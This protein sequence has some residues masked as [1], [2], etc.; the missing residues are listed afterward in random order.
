MTRKSTE[1]LLH[2]GYPRAKRSYI[3]VSGRWI[4]VAYSMANLLGSRAE[5]D[6]KSFRFADSVTKDIYECPSYALNLGSINMV[7]VRNFYVVPINSY[8]TPDNEGA[9]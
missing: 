5:V 1:F 2:K 9:N 4:P 8:E 7:R 3:S 6:P